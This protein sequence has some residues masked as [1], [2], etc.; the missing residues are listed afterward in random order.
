[1]VK[2][3]NMFG[4]EYSGK[5]GTA[6]VFAKWKGRQYRRKYVIPAN[7]KTSKQTNVRNNFTNAVANWHEFWSIQKRV[8][9]YL[10]AGQT[11]SGF[12]LWVSRYQKAATSGGSLPVQPLMGYRQFGTAKTTVSGEALT[13]GAADHTLAYNPAVMSSLTFSKG[14]SSVAIEAVVERERSVIRI[15]V[16]ITGAVTMDYTAGGRIITGEAI[17]TNPAAGLEQ[18][19]YWGPIDA[20]S[21]HVYVDGTEVDALEVALEAGAIHFT[22]TVPDTSDATVSYDYYTPLEDAKLEA[23]K[24]DTTFVVWREY[25]NTKGVMWVAATVEDQNYDM[26]ITAPGYVPG[27]YANVAANVVAKDEG[28]TMSTTNEP[29]VMQEISVEGRKTLNPS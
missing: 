20:G 26:T 7:P 13:S 8:F 10:G 15:P 29:A 16:A 22:N 9:S 3:T 14:T 24:A 17:A 25:S 1:M 23:V 19:I 18:R 12:N 21:V 27:T 11:L 2:V 6:G 5:V 28:L 4:D